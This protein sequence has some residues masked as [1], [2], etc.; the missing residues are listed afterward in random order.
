ME[1]LLTFSV[2]FGTQVHWRGRVQRLFFCLWTSGHGHL[3]PITAAPEWSSD[4][5]QDQSNFWSEKLA[6]VWKL[7]K[8]NIFETDK[9]T[10]YAVLASVWGKLELQL[11]VCVN[12]FPSTLFWITNKWKLSRS[13]DVTCNRG[14]NN[15]HLFA[16][17]EQFVKVSL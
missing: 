17:S 8:C 9:W 5:S 2:V 4:I 7:S 3:S 6:A 15:R 10:V 11:I 14:H 13:L 1:F 12:C 16:S